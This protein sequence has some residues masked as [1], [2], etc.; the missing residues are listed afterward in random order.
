MND[1][2]PTTPEPGP[3]RILVVDDEP[4]CRDV[5]V[6]QLNRLGHEASEASDGQKAL[7]QISSERYDLVI[8]D[9]RMPHL[10]GLHLL[11][12]I[13]EIDPLI[14]V[15]MISGYNV[16]ED[17]V[18]ALKLGAENFLAKPVDQKA[19]AK[20]VNQVLDQC[21]PP[22]EDD[23]GQMLINSSL[24]IIAPS[25]SVLA[26]QMVNR[27]AKASVSVGYSKVDLDSNLKLA[28]YEAITN[29]MEHGNKWDETKSV[30]ME[31]ELSSDYLRVTVED[32]GPGFSPPRA[33]DPTIG[34]G[35]LHNRGRGIFLMNAI[36]DQVEFVPPG[37]RV[38]LTKTSPAE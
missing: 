33:N 9:L 32:Q 31:A 24:R 35:L 21:C 23:P 29:A 2:S 37:N 34:D 18:E 16:L 20:V 6:R 38:V 11:D 36:M 26:G 17:V 1:R 10:D 30:L 28:I 4:P 25:R 8:T 7:Q 14:P 13:K 15:I 27:L 5:L 19:L 3:R 22:L 12:A